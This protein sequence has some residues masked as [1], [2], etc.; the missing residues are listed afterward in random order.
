MYIFEK[1]NN[2]LSVPGVAILIVH[3]DPL[4]DL[5]HTCNLEIRIPIEKLVYKHVS[6]AYLKKMNYSLYWSLELLFLLFP[7]TLDM[8][9]VTLETSEFGFPLK[10]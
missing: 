9:F 6:Y 8:A 7:W 10:K 3:L 5:C 1:M 4:D 2:S